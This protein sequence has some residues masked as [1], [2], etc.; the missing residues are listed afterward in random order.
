MK[1]I[2]AVIIILLVLSGCQST[3]VLSVPGPNGKPIAEARIA[4]SWGWAW[5]NQARVD[6]IHKVDQTG[7]VIVDKDGVPLVDKL[8]YM[9]HVKSGTGESS[10]RQV[11]QTG[12]TL[13]VI[14][15]TGGF[16]RRCGAGGC[17]GG[18]GTSFQIMNA[19]TSEAAAFSGA[20][21]N[22][23]TDVNVGCPTC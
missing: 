6:L 7:N 18:S 15:G 23:A 9:P 14:L 12:T 4:N 17:G 3:Q 20:D 16:G 1:K 13:G 21:V 22:N 19:P 5:D 8:E 11:I 10:A 2:G